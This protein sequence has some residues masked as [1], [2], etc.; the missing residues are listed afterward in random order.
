M[1]DK[2]LQPARTLV[3]PCCS[4]CAQQT[5]QAV[6]V[7]CC[8]QLE[9][10]GKKTNLGERKAPSYDFKPSVH[11][12]LPCCL[13]RCQAPSSLRVESELYRSKTSRSA[14]K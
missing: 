6:H 9:M 7:K 13:T 8:E 3:L 2:E 4:W 5:L 10:Q 12:S 14:K 1:L 11:L